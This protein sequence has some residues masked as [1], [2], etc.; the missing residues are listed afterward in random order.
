MNFTLTLM[1]HASLLCLISPRVH[2]VYESAESSEETAAQKITLSSQL[3]LNLITG[4]Y[5]QA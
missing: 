5:Q 4:I 1:S 3:F 2:T